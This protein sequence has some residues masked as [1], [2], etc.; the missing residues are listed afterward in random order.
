[1]NRTT[2]AE[3]K[4][5]ICVWNPFS[6]WRPKPAMAEAIRKQ[7][8][9]MRVTH[10]LNYDPLPEELPDTDIF[11]GYSLRADQLKDAKKLKWIHSTAAGVAQLMYPEL[12][13]SGIMVTN[14]SGIFSV[15]MSEHTMGL[16]LAL[17][18]NFPD[19]VRQQDQIV[20]SQQKIWDKPQHLSELNG[21]VLLIVGYGSIGREVAK[22][23]KAFEMKVWGV[24]RSG[25]GEQAHVEKIFAAAQLHEALPE[26]DYVLICAPE[27]A[28]TKHLIG[29]AEIAKMKRGA[30]LI[31][32]GRG[33]LL[34]EAAMIQALESGALGGAAL[35]VAATEPLPA[36]SPLWKAPNLFITPHTS[37]VSDR[38][39][40]RQ[41]EILIA[42][43]ER[44]FS[45]QKMF[46]QVDFAR[47]Y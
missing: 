31:N 44:W 23:A 22:R 38:L 39:W 8:P 46:N 10:L 41:T 24:T 33:S 42:L 1:M 43:L 35:D 47:G 21:K 5:V 30:R 18:R 19:C 13:D 20:W 9:A 26:A 2:P 45:G 32:I 3:T 7:W 34:D 6:E 25:T 16:L 27:T 4:L 12:R 28:E 36:E 14:P 29:A 11:V 15:P 37:G 40:N 17:S